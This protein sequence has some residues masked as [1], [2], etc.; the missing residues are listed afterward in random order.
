[1]QTKTTS[2][3]DKE[4]LLPAPDVAEGALEGELEGELEE[5][6][7]GA[8][9]HNTLVAKAMLNCG[10]DELKSAPKVLLPYL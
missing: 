7:G 2:V 10:P 4:G 8:L 3:A 5:E 6:L 1:M 9:V